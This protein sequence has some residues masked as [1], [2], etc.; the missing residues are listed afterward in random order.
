MNKLLP[1]MFVSLNQQRRI[2]VML[3]EVV[4]GE[5]LIINLLVVLKRNLR[6]LPF[7]VI[8]Q[9]LLVKIFFII[10]FLKMKMALDLIYKNVLIAVVILRLIESTNMLMFVE[11]KK[12]EKFLTVPR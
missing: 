10:I 12:I 9:K 8:Y 1:I 5:V 4:V 2:M 6:I 3:A 7:Q 11:E